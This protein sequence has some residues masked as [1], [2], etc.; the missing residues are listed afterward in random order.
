MTRVEAKQRTRGRLIEAT[1]EVLYREG[2]AKLTT[3]RVAA[4]AGVAQPTFYVHFASMDEALTEAA[5]RV[6]ERVRVRLRDYREGLGVESPREAVART[7]SSSLRALLAEPHM[8]EL[9]LRHR[10]DVSSPLGRRFRQ[11]ID[12]ARHDLRED[13]LRMG[14]VKHEETAAVQAELLVGMVLAATE[15]LLD[16]RLLEIATASRALTEVAEHFLRAAAAA[17]KGSEQAEPR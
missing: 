11:T 9:F 13:L 3:G 12:A 15:G 6:S 8:T 17:G 5:E 14:L 1:L 4:A 2:E 16:G 7:F 10:R